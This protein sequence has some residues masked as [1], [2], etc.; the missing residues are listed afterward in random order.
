MH[1][2]KANNQIDNILDATVDAGLC[3]DFNP[4]DAIVKKSY[5]KLLSHNSELIAKD[6]ITDT[7]LHALKRTFVPV[8][9]LYGEAY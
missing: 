2:I 4:H 6:T 5:T 3:I 9:L 1:I 7:L 8:A